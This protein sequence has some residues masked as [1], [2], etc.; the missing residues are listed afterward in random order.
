M[1]REFIEV[2]LFTK[3]WKE[4]GLNTDDLLRLQI[5]LK[6]ILNLDRLWKEPAGFAK[7]DFL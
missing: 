1:K 7:S 6:K 4:N 5:T 2:P 3:R